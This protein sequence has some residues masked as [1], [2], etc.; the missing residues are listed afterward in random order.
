M[1]LLEMK[2]IYKNFGKVQA[3]SDVN[4]TVE[5]GEAKGVLLPY[6]LRR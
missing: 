6:A 3:N 4:L 1:A 2:H 5:K